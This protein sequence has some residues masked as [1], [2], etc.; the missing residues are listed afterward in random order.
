M[1]HAIVGSLTA[2]L[3]G[4][5]LAL[6]QADE[7]LPPPRAATP[8]AAEAGA[9]P[10]DAGPLPPGGP[11]PQA[12][13]GPPP[14][15]LAPVCPGPGSP[16]RF[17]TS[18]EYNAW[19]F[20]KNNFPT[21]L[22]SFPTNGGAP[23]V[24][25]GG[26]S[27]DRE[28]HNGGGATLGAWFTDYQGFGAEG[29]FFVMES[30]G[31]SFTFGGGGTAGSPVIGRPF[32][33][34][35]SGLSGVLPISAPGLFNG[36]S[37]GATSGIQCDSGRFAGAELH[38]IGNITCDE[39]CRWDFLIGYR[40]LTLDDKFAMESTT[41][42]AN[43]LVSQAVLNGQQVNSIFDSINT[44]TRFNGAD[45]GL[46]WHW[47]CDRLMAVTTVRI[48]FGASDENASLTGST[49][50]LSFPTL[51]NPNGVA[52]TTPGGFLARPSNPGSSTEDFAVVA[53]GDLKLA[54]QVCDWMR[55]TVGYTVLYWSD[56]VR[57]GAQVNTNLN[58][59]EVPAL[60]P[61]TGQAPLPPLAQI[62]CTDFWA[63]GINV[64]L[65]FRY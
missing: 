44:S 17:W 29:G 20:K 56:V 31:K 58:R 50:S 30:T 47:Y 14:T 59:F 12:G 35:S 19:L 5:G 16:F 37:S 21:L 64:G 53:Q 49:S 10:A 34:V 63:H 22:E 8:P 52:T 13:Y 48:A 61:P 32:F 36:S 4:A 7:A 62:H 25:V 55:F 27:L 15:L 11:G 46:R 9:D 33:D 43:Q 40:Y 1:K 2:L 18:G 6:A 42:A 24:L 57:T 28:L 65:E 51:A 3:A 45:F 60:S 26:D 38:F 54:Y 39:G 23:H 41:T